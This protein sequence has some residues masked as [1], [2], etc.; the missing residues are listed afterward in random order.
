[1]EKLTKFWFNCR[2]KNHNYRPFQK[3]FPKGVWDEAKTIKLTHFFNQ[4]V[5]DTQKSFRFRLFVGPP[6]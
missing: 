1:M 5:M 6:F 2:D 3:Q 4:V